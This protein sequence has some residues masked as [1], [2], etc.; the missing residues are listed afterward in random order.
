MCLREAVVNHVKSH[1]RSQTT[2]S[3]TRFSTTSDMI[4][5]S[6]SV[7][8]IA[9]C[10]S[11]WKKSDSCAFYSLELQRPI[12]EVLTRFF[13]V[14]AS[15]TWFGCAIL[16]RFL[17]LNNNLTFLFSLCSPLSVFWFD[18]I[19]RDPFCICRRRSSVILSNCVDIFLAPAQIHA[20]YT[21][22]HVLFEVFLEFGLG[23]ISNF[24]NHWVVKVPPGQR[25][26]LTSRAA[27]G[28]GQTVVELISR[29]NS[30]CWYGWISR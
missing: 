23:F 12:V 1:F 13:A 9:F 16:S 15:W 4:I 27:S 6:N 20:Y 24:T 17:S 14:L 29:G 5:W 25:E 8:W 21:I 7:L 11:S 28:E 26:H 10:I 22:S 2:L 19:D 30:S 18:F 3:F